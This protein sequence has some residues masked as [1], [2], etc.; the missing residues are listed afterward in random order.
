[1]TVGCKFSC[2][3]TAVLC[4]LLSRD[5]CLQCAQCY[6]TARSAKVRR[7]QPKI[8]WR[9]RPR[10][11]A[12]RHWR[13]LSWVW[14]VCVAW[15]GILTAAGA[16]DAAALPQVRKLVLQ[17]MTADV[18]VCTMPLSEIFDF[19]C[20]LRMVNKMAD[21]YAANKPIIDLFTKIASWDELQRG[22][23][24]HVWL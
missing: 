7:Y 9:Q 19:S 6:V 16:E 22:P 5:G 17:G 13:L 11:R 15:K 4:W 21:D 8:C 12:A 20:S 24:N 18:M 1:M 3:E 14:D 2:C 10:M 23:P